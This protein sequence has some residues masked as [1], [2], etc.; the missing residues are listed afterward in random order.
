MSDISN[1]SIFEFT[2]AD[3]NAIGAGAH[4]RAKRQ[5]FLAGLPIAIEIDGI[6]MLLFED[7]CTEPYKSQ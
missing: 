1:K 7:G 4:E 2:V 6:T 5:A 3:C